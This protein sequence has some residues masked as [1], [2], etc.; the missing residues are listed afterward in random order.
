MTD[1]TALPDGLPVPEDDGAAAHLPGMRVPAM[2]LSASEGGRVDLSDRG[3][4]LPGP[5]YP[6][7]PPDRHAQQ[8]LEWMRA[9]VGRA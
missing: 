9:Q 5:F 6:V 2:E 4:R 8:V 7:F 3:L 1:H